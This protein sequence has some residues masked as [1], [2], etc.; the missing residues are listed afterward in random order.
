MYAM[1]SIG[2][3]NTR[4]EMDSL[5]SKTAYVGSRT[6]NEGRSSIRWNQWRNSYNL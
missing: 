2:E 6:F 5:I 3:N 4:T 1:F